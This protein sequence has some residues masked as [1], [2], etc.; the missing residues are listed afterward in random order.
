MNELQKI[1]YEKKH[2]VKIKWTPNAGSQT[3]VLA[4][5][6][7]LCSQKD[8]EEEISDINFILYHAGRGCGKSDTFCADMA[9]SIGVGYGKFFRAIVFRKTYSELEDF[10]KKA[11][12][13]F[14]ESGCFKGAK[15]VKGAKPHIKFKTGEVILFRHMLS[16]K[17]YDKYHGHEY[18]YI[19]FEELTLWNSE[20]VVTN[21]KSCL[22]LHDTYNE[23]YKREILEGKK[24]KLIGKIRASTNPYGAGKTW[25]KKKFIDAEVAGKFFL[26]NGI[27]TLHVK[28]HY[29][30][31]PYIKKSY[32]NSFFDISN[33]EKRLSWIFG[34]W[35]A[36]TGGVFG[37]LFNYDTFVLEDFEIPTNWYIDR[38]FDWGRTA[39]FSV[40]WFAE[41][42]G[43][44]PAYIGKNK[45]YFCPP[46]GTLI[47]F[48]EFY[49]KDSK[50]LKKNIGL[51]LSV[52]EISNGIKNIEHKLVSDKIIRNSNLINDGVADSAIFSNNTG[53]D[54]NTV[55]DLFYS[56]GINWEKGAKQGDS[57]RVQR[58]D[59]ML[60]RMKNTI[61]ND[62]DRPQI[63]VNENCKFWI[64]NIPA[65]QYDPKR[66]GDVD[67]TSEDHDWD[68][69]GYRLC[70][71]R[72]ESKSGTIGSFRK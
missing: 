56:E 33:A 57:G 70:H 32:I 34:D 40:L 54:Q 59:L 29:S 2:N 46:K 63:Y 69:T 23:T 42:D 30:E 31:N 50:E 41:A 35:S 68:A 65:L 24:K 55:Y 64:E 48:Q 36:K 3:L 67:T 53:H 7:V 27:S 51:N 12:N 5:S 60:E 20:D 15:I 11:E 49:G 28:G 58:V 43:Y 52:A 61:L 14:I 17:D 1:E 44:T 21:M 25:V 45:R 37:D 10:I 71:R 22:R 19:L 6:N 47:I 8:S 4:A 9:A 18:S 72:I 26:Q 39:P 16:E 13:F 66:P 38:S 62:P